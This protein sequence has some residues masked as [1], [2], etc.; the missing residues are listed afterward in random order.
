MDWVSQSTPPEQVDATAAQ[1]YYYNKSLH[2]YNQTKNF[3]PTLNLDPA[4]VPVGTSKT[5]CVNVAWAPFKLWHVIDMY[6]QVKG[7]PDCSGA[8]NRKTKW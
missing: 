8:Y 4:F 6:K 7:Q 2:V 3:F 5:F 1:T